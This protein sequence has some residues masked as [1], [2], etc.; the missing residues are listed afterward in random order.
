LTPLFC[1][2]TGLDPGEKI[3]ELGSRSFFLYC[4]SSCGSLCASS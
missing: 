4:S 1:K 3:M 2:Q